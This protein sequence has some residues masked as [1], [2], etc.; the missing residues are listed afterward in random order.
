MCSTTE[1][2]RDESDNIEN[3]G[4]PTSFAMEKI[5]AHASQ[6]GSIIG[7]GK[8]RVAR[9]PLEYKKI[10]SGRVW[11]RDNATPVNGISTCVADIASEENIDLCD[12]GISWL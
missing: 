6:C 1:I 10:E 9:R 4:A 3:L 8:I 2:S 11:L 7:L 5:V 12:N